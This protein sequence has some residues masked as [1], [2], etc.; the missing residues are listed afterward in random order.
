MVV[1]YIM[2]GIF[3]YTLGCAYGIGRI[4]F[5]RYAIDCISGLDAI[6]VRVVFQIFFWWACILFRIVRWVLQKIWTLLL[7]MHLR[8]LICGSYY[9]IFSTGCA[10]KYLIWG[11]II[12]PYKYAFKLGKRSKKDI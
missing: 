12:A 11:P 7:E 10:F 2:A 8:W 5:A 3:L 9:F 6:C 1:Y 4:N